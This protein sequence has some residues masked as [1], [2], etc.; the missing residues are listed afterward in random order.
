MYCMSCGKPNADTSQFCLFC[1]KPLPM[2]QPPAM[3]QP[4]SPFISPAP[5]KNKSTTVVT[6]VV[7]VAALLL[8]SPFIVGFVIGF[9]RGFN[10]SIEGS[11]QKVARLMRE[12]AGVQPVQKP[13]F[14]E[15]KVDTKLRDLF[16]QVIQLN[17]DYQADVDRLDIS[18]TQKLATAESFADPGTAAEGLRQLHAAYDLDA[19]QEQ[20]LGRIVD[21]FK[22]QF[23][24]VTGW[25]HDKIIEGFNKGLA[26]S[27][28]PRQRATSTEKAWIDA[29]DD[30]YNYAELH[31]ADFA[32]R[33]GQLVIA[34]DSERQEFNTKVDALNARRHEFQQAQAEFTRFQG[35]TWQKMG[36]SGQEVG[37][38]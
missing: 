24:D 5:T 1:G 17:K 2:M 15:D 26:Q 19:K 4:P 27:M 11:D 22:H 18:Q 28:G 35:A 29:M 14:G 25:E 12:A 16:R 9:A 8:L 32:M 3:P 38:H 13:L 36:V 10:S 20:K 23:D 21:D 34:D 7:V 37:A 31:H 30:V 6:V 33:Y